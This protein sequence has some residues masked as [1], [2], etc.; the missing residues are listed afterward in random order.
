MARCD[1]CGNEYHR[2]FQLLTAAGE[3]LT[4]DCFECAIHL[5]A[6]VCRRCKCRI[7]G[8][9]IEAAGAFYCCAHCAREGG[10]TGAADHV[11]G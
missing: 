4:F 11:A 6:P 3:T 8:H 9:G 7:I 5:L 2:A 10:I 1:H